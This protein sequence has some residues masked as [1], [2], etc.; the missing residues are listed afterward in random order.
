MPILR[1]RDFTSLAQTQQTR[2]VHASTSTEPF[3]D[4]AGMT[5]KKLRRR[6]ED[7]RNR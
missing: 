5:A 2:L 6:V 3:G 1:V 7:H 4:F